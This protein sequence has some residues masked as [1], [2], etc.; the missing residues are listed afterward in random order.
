MTAAR[1]EGATGRRLETAPPLPPLLPADNPESLLSI[2]LSQYLKNKDIEKIWAA[3]RF[4]EQAHEGQM[5]KS[6]EPYISHPV[7]VACQLADLHLDVPTIIAALLHDV[8]EDTKI[9]KQQ[10]AEQFGNQVAELVDG[11]SKLEKIEFQSATEAQAENFRKMLLA[12]S[13]DVRVILVKLADRLHN[14]QT[15]DVMKPDKRRRIAKETLEIYA[16]IANRLGLNAIYQEL[17]DL[18][19]KNYYP[20]R[21]RILSK[22]ILAARGNRKE[23]VGKVSSEIRARL[24]EMKIEAEVSGREKHLYSVYRKMIDK[25]L[26]FA[27]IYD[28]YGFRIIVK[29]LPSCYLTLGVLHG[30]Y[31][32]IPGKFKDYIAIPKA[33]GY[34]SLHSTLFGP[35]GTP[36]EVQIRSLEMHNVAE[37]GVAA[38]WLYKTTDAHLTNLQQQTHQWLQ[39]LLEIQSESADSMEFLEHL[40]VDLF[41]DEVYVFTPKGKILAL[42]KGATAVDFA[43]AVHT[44]IGNRC[45]AVKINQELAPLRTELRNGDNVE[46]ITAAHAHPNPMWLNYVVSGKARA[47][48]RHFLKSIQTKESA[49]LGERL[50][51]Q[52]MR[53]LHADESQI[54]DLQWQKL[55]KDYGAKDKQEILTDIGLGKRLNV[56]VAHQL[57]ALTDDYMARPLNPASKQLD[58]ITIRGTEGMAVQLAHCCR[59]IPGDPILG[60]INKDKGLVIHTHDCPA[61][62]KFR[63]D[64]DKWLDV[65]WDPETKRLFKVNLKMI[66]ADQRGVLA[67]IAAAIAEAGSNIDNISMEESDNSAYTNILFTVQIENRLHLA[68]LMRRLR[69]LP[70]VVR[71]NRVKG[72]TQ[73]QRVQ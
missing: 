60:F 37:A 4:S 6:G 55:L 51:H 72:T 58:T 46:I 1:Y 11:L 62:R 28:I 19:F 27:Q 2:K 48:I 14:M 7:A 63:L 65:E 13:Q 67:K 12:M 52:A 16:P 32:P 34:Q 70:D 21:F 49:Q 50:L 61:I 24:Q 22:A 26:D 9:T 64:P 42:P 71:I 30:L 39:R 17:E 23:V 36:I 25:G 3:Y 43:Y 57:L 56:M 53:A 15:L 54:G 59:P 20:F 68:D 44:D 38:H 47:H 35:F 40:K 41:P 45:V 18:S 73:E 69:K 5:R 8:V 10:V 31:K 66:V 29:D 33:N